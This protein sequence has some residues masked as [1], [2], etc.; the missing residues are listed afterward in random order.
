MSVGSA[1]VTPVRPGAKV[2]VPDSPTLR[3]A[4][5]CDRC[6]AQAFVRV[7]FLVGD[8][9]HELFFCGHH[10]AANE[11]KLNA[12]AQVVVDERKFIN[13]KSESST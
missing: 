3:L 12:T 9:T 2:I 6:A 4:D 13:A 5:R 10:Y 8:D 11:Q 7:D 1:T